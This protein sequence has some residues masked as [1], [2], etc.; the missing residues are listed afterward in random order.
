MIEK[1]LFIAGRGANTEYSNKRASGQGG[2]AGDEGQ[3]ESV[4]LVEDAADEG[5]DHEADSEHGFHEG[6]HRRAV[7]GWSGLLSAVK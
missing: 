4:D 7:P 1:Y 3:V 2:P 5:A 6:Q